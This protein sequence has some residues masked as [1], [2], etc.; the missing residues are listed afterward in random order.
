MPNDSGYLVGEIENVCAVTYIFPAN[1]S[2]GFC[3]TDLRA[4][5]FSCTQT[6]PGKGFRGPLIKRR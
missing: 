4:Y 2:L 6:L 3:N 5:F 1:I